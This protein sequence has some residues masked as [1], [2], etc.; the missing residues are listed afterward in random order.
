MADIE[1]YGRVLA[2]AADYEKESAT[3]IYDRLFATYIPH[4]ILIIVGF[5]ELAIG[6]P[7]HP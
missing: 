1:I 3:F 5:I 6:N 7:L 2:D 4:S